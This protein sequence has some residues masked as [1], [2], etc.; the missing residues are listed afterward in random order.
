MMFGHV[1]TLEDRIEHLRRD[2]RGAGSHGRLYR[3][4]RLDLPGREHE[5]GRRGGDRAEYLRTLAV[6]RV[7]LDNV[8]N[9]QA[10]WVTQ[11]PKLGAASLAFG[12][13]RHGQHDD[14]GECRRVGRYGSRDARA[15]DCCGDPGRRVDPPSSGHD[16]FEAG[17]TDL[18][19]T[20]YFFRAASSFNT[21]SI[22]AWVDFENQPSRNS[23]M[24]AA[25]WARIRSTVA[26]RR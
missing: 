25:S 3:V 15:T 16:L 17:G 1:E 8:D 5:T 9:I 21:P 18:R 19:L 23:P 10:S 14:R 7:F 11:G 24:K 12:C 13:Q 22:R 26:E 4:H 6:I 20:P 2:P